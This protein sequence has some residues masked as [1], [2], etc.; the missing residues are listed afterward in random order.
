LNGIF[1]IGSVHRLLADPGTI[2]L[3]LIDVQVDSYLGEGDI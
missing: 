1:T 2:P 3:E